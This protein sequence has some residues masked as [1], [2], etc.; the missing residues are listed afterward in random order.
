MRASH[1][2]LQGNFRGVGAFDLP[3]HLPKALPWGPRFCS[4]FASSGHWRS[5]LIL[6]AL[7]VVSSTL[8]NRP[9]V[10]GGSKGRRQWEVGTTVSPSEQ[11]AEYLLCV[12]KK[13]NKKYVM[14]SSEGLAHG[15]LS[16]PSYLFPSLSLREEPEGPAPLG[17]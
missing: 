14:G 3:N 4:L 10:G 7:K 1:P 11:C 5:S 6:V 16:H 9:G 8:H 2:A 12:N 13:Y 17:T 15:T